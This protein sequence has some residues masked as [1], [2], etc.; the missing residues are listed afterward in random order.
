[1][2]GSVLNASLINTVD[3]CFLEYPLSWTFTMLNFFIDPFIILI[4][5]P[6]ESVQYLGLPSIIFGLLRSAIWNI[7]VRFSNESYCSF[8]AF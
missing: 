7:R 8:Q 3:I 1:M 2:F 6:Y 5:F 4:N